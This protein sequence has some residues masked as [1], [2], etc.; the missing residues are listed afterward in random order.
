MNRDTT[1]QLISAAVLTASLGLAGLLMPQLSA[2]ASDAQLYYTD[3]T[4]D[5]ETTASITD[6]A[7]LDIARS[8]GVLRGIAVNYLW[9]RAD[10]LKEDG[11]FF[12]AYQIARWITQLQPRFARVWQ[13]QA[14]NMAYNISVAT[15]TPE[16]RWDWVQNGI[17][18]LREKGI[19]YNPGDMI[20]YKELA[21]HFMHKVGGSTDDAHRYYKQQMARRWQSIIGEPPYEY[22]ARMDQIRAIAEAPSSMTELRSQF[23]EVDQIVADLEAINL[24]PGEELLRQ[25]EMLSAI[26]TSYMGQKLGLDDQLEQSEQIEQIEDPS[27][28]AIVSLLARLRPIRDNAEYAE[29]WPIFVNHVRQTVLRENYNMEPEFMLKYMEEFGPLDWRVP[30]S[31]ALYW[32]ALGVERALTRINQ[33]EFDQINTDRLLFH[34]TQNQ[35]FFGRIY[36]DYLTGE[37]SWGQD[38]RYIPYY[39]NAFEIILDRMPESYQRATTFIDGYRNFMIDAVR[40]YYQWGEYEKAQEMYAKLR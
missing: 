25:I 29:A 7:V 17:R 27:V 1:I 26:Q 9:I 32:A 39:E 6:E 34:S 21:W 24:P 18:L 33:A 10:R 3:L 22:E 35:K 30:F 13:F 19:R 23:P 16:E 11:K 31:H 20:L 38:L 2:K 12:E 40:E 36:F 37:I 8:V 28:R 5:R 4:S 14:W 15:H